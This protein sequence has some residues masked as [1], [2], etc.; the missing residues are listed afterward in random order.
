[1]DKKNTKPM[2][3]KDTKPIRKKEE[4]QQSNDEHIDQDF[5]GFPHAPSKKETISHNGSANA[6][7]GTEYSGED[8]DQFTDQD[9]HP[10]RGK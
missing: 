4:V 10:D 6:F 5:P 7:K 3:K 8:D 9:G 1:M 2:D